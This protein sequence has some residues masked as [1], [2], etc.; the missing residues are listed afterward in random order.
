MNI[1]IKNK[2]MNILERAESDIEI[3]LRSE[4]GILKSQKVT[5]FKDK[6]M[7]DDI[8]LTSTQPGIVIIVAEA[9]GFEVANTSV[10]FVPPSNPSEL[11][12]TARPNENILAN[13]KESTKLTVKLLNPDGSLFVPQV[14]KQIDIWTDKGEKLQPIKIYKDK[15]YVQTEFK[16]YKPGTV[17]IIASSPD[18]S[19]KDHAIVKFVSP[20]TLLTAFIALLGG[21][22]GGIV[23][24]YQDHRKG[25]SFLPKRKKDGTWQ[26]GMLG[27][28][29][30]HAFFG[31]IVFVAAFLNIP[32]TNIFSLPVD[33]WYG[34]FIIGLMGGLY[35]FAIISS[36]GFLFKKKLES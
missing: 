35:F 21:F 13:G 26:L 31:V 15:P 2:T 34:V 25:I 33:V 1:V 23:K 30:F 9:V 7:S 24:Y 6:A 10:E 29:V 32:L 4:R 20:I 27:D 14:D 36:W 19:L 18:F 17:E 3:L 8:S 28:A 16:T 22:L 12:L 5:I 11:K